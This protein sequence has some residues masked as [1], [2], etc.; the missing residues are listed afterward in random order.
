MKS[1]KNGKKIKLLL[2]LVLVSLFFS[3]CH[4]GR[5]TNENGEKVIL[6]ST[7]AAYD[8][9]REIV[10]D[11]KGVRV[12]ILVD[13]GVDLHS[14]QPKAQDILKIADCDVFV[15]VGGESDVWVQD[16]IQQSGNDS[17]CEV[18]MLELVADH[19]L[20]EE[21]V[22]FEHEETDYH[23][24]H[25]HSHD[26]HGH[27]HEGEYDEHIWLSPKNAILVCYEIRNL[28]VQL[29]PEN[30]EFYNRNWEA[31]EQELRNLDAA[32]QD[33]VS[34]AYFNTIIVGDRFPF[35][36]LVR[37]Y[38]IDYYAAYSGCSADAEASVHMVTYLANRMY[39]ENLP[40]IFT[41]DQGNTALCETVIECR[42]VLQGKSESKIEIRNLDSM[43]S[44][45]GEQIEEGITYLSVMEENLANL[46]QALDK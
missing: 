38:D 33:M 22:D 46:K 29:D 35:L 26:E 17:L 14:Y 30:Q 1:I 32:F 39:E 4:T 6:C 2:L 23:D 42:D 25:E 19:A 9:T 43:Q 21:H 10:G 16:A 45:T 37:E 36:Y 5:K 40:V 13:N 27:S 20:E 15:Y 18:S 41:V 28:V 3:S 24:E 8:W 34:E 11:S 44:I 7:F 12:E 31:Y